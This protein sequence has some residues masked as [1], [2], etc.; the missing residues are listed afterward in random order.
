MSDREQAVRD[1]LRDYV[2]ACNEGSA[3]AYMA[4]LTADAVSCPPGQPPVQGREAIGT[5]VKDG[6]FDVFDVDF[7]ADFD[8]IIVADDEVLA[9]GRFSLDL[10]PKAGGEATTLTG[11]FFNIFREDSPGSWKYAWAVW[12]WQQPFG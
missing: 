5:W 4:T 9:P 12:N 10:K 11:T 6:F 1:T 7:A 8:R 2:T 3:E